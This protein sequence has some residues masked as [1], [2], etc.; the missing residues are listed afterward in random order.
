M[1]TNESKLNG[2]CS[3][4]LS[5]T[6]HENYLLQ[7]LPFSGLLKRETKSHHILIYVDLRHTMVPHSETEDFTFF[8]SP[9]TTEGQ[10]RPPLFMGSH[11]GSESPWGRTA[12][13][14]WGR[15]L[16]EKEP[17]G[18]WY[19][20]WPVSTPTRTHMHTYVPTWEMLFKRKMLSYEGSQLV[21]LCRGQP[22]QHWT[23]LAQILPLPSLPKIALEVQVSM[24]G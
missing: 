16:S 17:W 7:R 14:L 21:A 10:N 12:H 22:I 24:A 6:C 13:R 11:C 18:F 1:I 3:R 20:P 15:C 5:A 4:P 9:I 8:P 23:P 19:P 2:A